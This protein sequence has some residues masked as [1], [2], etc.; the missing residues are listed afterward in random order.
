MARGRLVR[1]AAPGDVERF[2]DDMGAPAARDDDPCAPRSSS[3]ARRKPRRGSA[4]GPKGAARGAAALERPA[5]GP[6]CLFQFAVAVRRLAA[7]GRA[8]AADYVIASSCLMALVGATFGDEPALGLYVALVAG[9]SSRRPRP[10]CRAATG[11]RCA[12]TS[13][14]AP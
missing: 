2:L 9:A 4:Q 5:P 14:A 12:A 7:A 13:P 3:W 10:C 6:G 8:D 1:C 11:P